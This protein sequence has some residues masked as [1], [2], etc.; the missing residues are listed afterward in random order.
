MNKESLDILRASLVAS[1]EMFGGTVAWIEES[2][3]ASD[4]EMTEQQA[5]EMV[6]LRQR[7]EVIQHGIEVCDAEMEVIDGEVEQAD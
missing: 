5:K 7:I 6:I 1:L 3:S 2:F 4:I